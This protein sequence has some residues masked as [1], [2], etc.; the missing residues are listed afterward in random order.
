MKKLLLLFLLVA[1]G[2]STVSAWGDLYLICGEN[3][4]WNNSSSYKQDAFKFTCLAENQYRAT[5]PGSYITSSTWGFRFRDAS[6][7][8]WQN[9]SPES[10]QYDATLPSDGTAYST[11]WQNSSAKCFIIAQN[12][13]AKYVH[14]YCNWNTS[15]SKWDVSY[16]VVTST[17]DYKVAYTNPSG[18]SDVYVYAFLDGVVL[19][20][21]WPGTKLS[22]TDGVYKSTITGAANSRVIFNKGTSGDGNQSWTMDVVNEGV[23]DYSSQIS[24]QTVTVS[25]YGMSTFCSQ[26]P[27]DFSTASPSGLKAYKITESNKATGE[28]T[29]VE[30]TKVPANVG[31]YIE[32]ASGESSTNY[33]VSPTA[34]ATSIGDN[35]L[36]GVTE[37]T[38]I[39]Q[40]ADEGATT[41]YILTVNTDGG[42]MDTPKFYKVNY[43]YGNTVLANRAY[44]QIPTA[45]AARESFW[46]DGDVT[47]IE[48]NLTPALNEG[49]VYDLQGRRVAQPM[50]GLYIVN[51][52]KVIK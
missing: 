9:I 14:I 21:A 24:S 11:D 3:N 44:L 5:V 40:L 2:V 20:S 39:I 49:V 8:T 19:T 15:T 28:L 10:S 17:T 46:F 32:G 31:V 36:V 30:V 6:S 18:W 33:T 41:N 23:Y 26:Y 4:S 27:L 7:D 51:G 38:D 37:N 45:E 13:S 1:G 22:L 29:K 50:K 48:K 25:K 52:K 12:A 47:A 35:M 16:S 42:N 34:T 43:T